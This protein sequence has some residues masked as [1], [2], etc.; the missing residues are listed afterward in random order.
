MPSC[1]QP[2]HA[3]MAAPKLSERRTRN[4]DDNSNNYGDITVIQVNLSTPNEDV[5]ADDIEYLKR[6]ETL[7]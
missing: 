5:A 7:T 3:D 2:V 6:F 4:I 1:K